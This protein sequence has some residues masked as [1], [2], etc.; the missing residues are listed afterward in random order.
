[1]NKEDINKMDAT[2]FAAYIIYTV[3]DYAKAN[4]YPVTDTVKTMGQN[5]VYITEKLNLD[6]WKGGGQSES[7]H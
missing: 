7:E 3:C 2:D 4:G 5:L 6:N 1:M